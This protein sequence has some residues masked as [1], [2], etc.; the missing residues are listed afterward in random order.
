MVYLPVLALS[1]RLDFAPLPE[2]GTSS[3]SPEAVPQPVSHRIR[4]V[5]LAFFEDGHSSQFGPLTQIRPVFELVCGRYSLRERLLRRLPQTRWGAFVRPEL[6][7][8]YA[9]DNPE[10]VV[11]DFAWLSSDETLLVNGRWLPTADELRDLQ[12]RGDSTPRLGVWRNELMYAVLT[13]GDAELFHRQQTGPLVE[14]LSRHS[15]V[16]RVARCVSWPWELVQ[17]NPSQLMRDFIAAND[18]TLSDNDPYLFPGVSILGSRDQV[19]ID[20]HAQIEP[21]VVIDARPGPV[22]IGP[23][24]VVHAFTRIEGPCHI[25]AGTRL[26]RAS[27][28]GG[29]SVGPDCRVGGEIE[30]SI[31]HAFVNK[32]HDGFLGHSYVCPWVNIGA[33]TLNSDLKVDYTTVHVPVERSPVDTGLMK[34][35]C[36]YGDHVKTGLGCLFNT[37]TVIGVMAQV[38]PSGTLLP[39]YIPAFSRVRYGN[40][41]QGISFERAA[42][43]IRA[44]MGRRNV[45]LTTAAEATLKF[46]HAASQPDRE[47][48]AMRLNPPTE[49]RE[50]QKRLD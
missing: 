12:N 39:K 33:Q 31:L 27:I 15:G 50:S 42:T 22:S 34:V 6:E 20:R 18:Q 11:N 32:Y 37:G 3:T 1:K 4:P 26:F 10:A 2:R 48:A 38:L 23:G 14:R 43:V 7:L 36:F 30:A 49:P 41:E 45:P 47:A 21:C 9:E 46:V 8:V 28:R 29:C 16:Q 40:V 24:A 44:A 25:G 17:E 5:Q 19:A 13:P 35:G